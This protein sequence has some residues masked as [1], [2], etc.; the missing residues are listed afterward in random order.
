M[1]GPIPLSRIIQKLTLGIAAAFF[2]AYQGGKRFLNNNTSSVPAPVINCVASAF[3]ELTSTAVGAPA[4]VIKQNA[5][6]L[7]RNG[8][9]TSLRA[10]R[11][12]GRNPRNFWRGYSLLAGRNLPF[13]AL[14]FPLYEELKI[15]LGAEKVKD[16]WWEMSKVTAIAAGISGGLAAWITTPIDVVKTRIMLS[17][18]QGHKKVGPKEVFKNILKEEGVIELFRGGGMRFFWT[19]IGSGMYLAVYEGMATW[20]E[21]TD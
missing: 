5:Q 19:I 17:A 20:L 8:G 15:I 1:F 6:V 4:E 3:A 14:Q 13:I 11:L 2:T 9:S 16:D 18:T 21:T 7:K 10:L 12:I